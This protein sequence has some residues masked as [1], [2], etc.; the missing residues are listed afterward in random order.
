MRIAATGMFGTVTWEMGPELSAQ[1][2]RSIAK[3][4]GVAGEEMAKDFERVFVE[5]AQGIFKIAA[6]NAKS[7]IY[8]PHLAL[9]ILATLINGMKGANESALLLLQAEKR[10]SE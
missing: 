7:A 1:Y 4:K 8:V 6:L 10:N 9:I 2:H 5:Q 3:V